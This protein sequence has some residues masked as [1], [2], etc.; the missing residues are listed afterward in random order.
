[1][2]WTNPGY[3]F[4]RASILVSVPSQSGVYV[5][6]VP[7]STTWV[8]VGESGDMKSRLLQHWTETGTCIKG[9]SPLGF[10]LELWDADSRVARQDHWILELNPACN[11]RLG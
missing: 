11:H 5:I 4:D 2:P 8:Y 7:G 1:M 10:S 6:Y 9:Y 3:A